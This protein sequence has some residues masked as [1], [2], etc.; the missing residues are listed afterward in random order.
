MSISITSRDVILEAL[1]FPEGEG[2]PNMRFGHYAKTVGDASGGSV[3][4][5]LLMAP[6][7]Y[8][9]I[10]KPMGCA[11]NLENQSANHSGR[12]YIGGCEQ[13]VGGVSPILAHQYI[14]IA[15]AGANIVRSGLRAN[16][17]VPQEFYPFVRARKPGQFNPVMVFESNT[18][19]NTIEY[20]ASVWGYIYPSATK[21]VG[22]RL[23]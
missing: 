1:G 21:P 9:G 8:D 19:T 6:F 3:A 20:S 15:G 16:F 7:N 14:E 11:F 22:L 2:W 17:V 13:L 12:I 10:I 5:S 18:N 23:P 4:M